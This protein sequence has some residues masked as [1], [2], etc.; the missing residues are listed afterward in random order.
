MRK[1]PNKKKRK[2]LFHCIRHHGFVRD[3]S[4]NIG[5]DV[6][7]W[8]FWES[9]IHPWFQTDGCSLYVSLRVLQVSGLSVLSLYLSE[10]HHLDYSLSLLLSMLRCREYFQNILPHSHF[11]LSHKDTPKTYL[12]RHYSLCLC[13]LAFLCDSISE[14]HPLDHSLFLCL[15]PFLM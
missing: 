5:S 10:N 8:I 2:K 14:N 3:Q 11:S 13:L 4:E 1:I 6:G 15:S 12:Q 9:Q 7:V